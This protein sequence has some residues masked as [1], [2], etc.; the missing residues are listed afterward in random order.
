MSTLVNFMLGAL[1][2]AALIAPQVASDLG[3]LTQSGISLA[4][5]AGPSLGHPR[6]IPWAVLRPGAS[7]NS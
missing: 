3:K 5:H 6:P 2:A 7:G 4:G 1:L